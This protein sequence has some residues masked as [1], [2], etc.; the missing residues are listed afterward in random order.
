MVLPLTKPG[1]FAGFLFVFVLALGSS[2]E[3]QLLGGAGQSMISI[4]IDDVM[5]VLNFPLAFAI[6]SVVVLVLVALLY[7]GN[8]FVGLS[9]LFE[10]F[11]W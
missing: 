11:T 10:N 1:I 5:R 9:R 4:M 3:V 2:V 7:L 6:S 8:R